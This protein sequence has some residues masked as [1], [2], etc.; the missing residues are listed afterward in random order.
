MVAVDLGAAVAGNVLH[1]RQHAAIHEARRVGP[2]QGHDLL[3]VQAV[4]A[5]ADD[6]MGALLGHV[7]NGQ[8]IGGDADVH[9]ILG[10][11]AAGMARGAECGQRIFRIELAEG[12]GGRIFPPA[13]AT[14]GR[15]A[16]PCRLPDR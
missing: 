13:V 8:A 16:G 9:E 1:H 10:H 14:G 11:E 15:G 5:V 12:A 4:G 3:D 7:E 6:I 2:G